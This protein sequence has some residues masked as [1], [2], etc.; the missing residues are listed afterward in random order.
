MGLEKLASEIQE[1]Y[2]K[3]GIQDS[4]PSDLNTLKVHETNEYSMFTIIFESALGSTTEAGERGHIN[5]VSIPYERSNK[6]KK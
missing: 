5:F 3:T 1:L 6:K 4:N 2:E